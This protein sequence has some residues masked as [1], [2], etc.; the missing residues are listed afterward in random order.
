MKILFDHQIYSNQ[1]FGGISR[2]F[3]MLLTQLPLQN[4]A[5]PILGVRVSSNYYLREC[6]YPGYKHVSARLHFRGKRPLFRFINGQKCRSLLSKGEYD[7]FHPTYFDPYFLDYIG[8]RPFVITVYDLIH[9]LFPD[10]YV[11]EP[12]FHRW[13]EETTKSASAIIAISESTKNDLVRI[14]GVKPERVR[15]VHLGPALLKDD[16]PLANSFLPDRFILFVGDRAGYKNFG[17]LIEAI[18]SV[19]D[20][21]HTLQLVCAGGGSFTRHERISFETAGLR[22]R[23]HQVEATDSGLKLL[24]SNAVALIYPSRYEGFGMPV[25]EALEYGC[26]VITTEMSSIPEIAGEAALYVSP[27][28]PESIGLA[29]QRLIEDP[30]LRNDLIIKGHAQARQFTWER[31]AQETARVYREVLEKG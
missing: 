14:Y 25:L 22:G 17:A 10:L 1:I 2:Y 12:N 18:P 13:M 20:K 30:L 5:R 6:G 7:V 29:L 11:E 8:S 9:D 3:S 28:N 27:S 19:F 16:A 26:P 24:Y 15:V 23:I 4:L 31:T 21:D